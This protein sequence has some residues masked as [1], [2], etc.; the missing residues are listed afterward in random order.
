MFSGIIEVV[1]AEIAIKKRAELCENLNQ[2]SSHTYSDY[3]N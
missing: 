3:G 1:W 2:N